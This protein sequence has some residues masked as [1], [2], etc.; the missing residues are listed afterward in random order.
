MIRV[1]SKCEKQLTPQE[2]C[3]EESKGMEAERKS[4]GLQGVLFRY[5]TC[6]GCGTADIFVDV[7]TLEGESEADFQQRRGELEA[8]VRQLHSEQTAVVLVERRPSE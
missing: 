2:L 6:A 7:L 5:Y 8:V 1:C 3:R 4:L